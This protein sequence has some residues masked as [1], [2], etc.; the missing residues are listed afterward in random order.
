MCRSW[1]YGMPGSWSAQENP[2]FKVRYNLSNLYQQMN[3]S[4]NVWMS[5]VLTFLVILTCSFHG[6]IQATNV[7]LSSERWNIWMERLFGVHLW[8]LDGRKLNWSISLRGILSP[9]VIEPRRVARYYDVMCLF[10][11]VVFSFWKPMYIPSSLLIFLDAHI[12]TDYIYI[13]LKIDW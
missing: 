11:G 8:S 9:V 6:R 4:G 2:C 13:T 5:A 12:H 7:S 10:C 1:S 3:L